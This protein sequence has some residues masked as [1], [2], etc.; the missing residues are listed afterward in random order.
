M[1]MCK[2]EQYQHTRNHNLQTSVQIVR[3]LDVHIK[4]VFRNQKDDECKGEILYLQR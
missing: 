1:L 3:S 4:I 2:N